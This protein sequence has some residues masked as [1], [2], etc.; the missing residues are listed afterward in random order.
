MFRIDLFKLT[1]KKWGGNGDSCMVGSPHSKVS[2]FLPGLSHWVPG[3]DR[4]EVV[5]III[6]TSGDKE[7]IGDHRNS[8]SSPWWRKLSARH[9]P[10]LQLAATWVNG[11]LVVTAFLFIFLIWNWDLN[12]QTIKTYRFPVSPIR[13]FVTWQTYLSAGELMQIV[14]P[15][16]SHMQHLGVIACQDNMCTFIHKYSVPSHNCISGFNKII[17]KF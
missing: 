17:K 5:T 7:D 8:W 14:A 11:H 15:P 12:A 10:P 13:G 9:L 4:G 3:E 16:P 6:K 1:F 2:S